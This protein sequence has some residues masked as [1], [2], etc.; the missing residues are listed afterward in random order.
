MSP[1]SLQLA[2]PPVCSLLAFWAVRFAVC[3]GGELTSEAGMVSG[4]QQSDS[5]TRV[6]VS[7]LY[8]VLFSIRLLQSVEPSSLCSKAG[9][10]HRAL[11]SACPGPAGRPRSSPPSGQPRSRPRDG[12]AGNGPPCTRRGSPP[13]SVALAVPWGRAVF[14]PLVPKPE[15]AGAAAFVASCCRDASGGGGGQGQLPLL[16]AGRRQPA[17]LAHRL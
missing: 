17:G 1:P 4:A 2:V 3:I 13:W 15:A 12:G 8:R 9:P 5:V 14:C 10:I 16:R 11:V 6:P 7:A